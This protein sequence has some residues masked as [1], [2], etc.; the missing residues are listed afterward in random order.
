MSFKDF[1]FYFSS[2]GHFVQRSGRILAILVKSHP[3]NF[4]IKIILESAKWSRRRC[5]LKIFYLWLWRPFCSSELNHCS[6]F[7][8]GS[9]KKY[10]NIIFLKSGHWSRRR[11]HVKVFLFLASVAI[12]FCGAEQF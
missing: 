2:G 3:R 4:S 5:H 9:S 1:F 8:R 10:F 7:G 12:L 11:C 6:N